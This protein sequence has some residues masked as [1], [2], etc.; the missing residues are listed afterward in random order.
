MNRIV[1]HGR[2]E[3][4]VLRMRCGISVP[5]HGH[6]IRIARIQERVRKRFQRKLL[7]LLLLLKRMEGASGRISYF[8]QPTHVLVCPNTTRL[9]N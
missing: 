4:V 1:T 2:M 6:S 7:L 5:R 8:G 3:R 9:I